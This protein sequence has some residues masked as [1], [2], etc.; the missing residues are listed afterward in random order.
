MDATYGTLESDTYIPINT[1]AENLNHKARTRLPQ[2]VETLLKVNQLAQGQL[3]IANSQK[4][5]FES[6]WSFKILSKK[7]DVIFD[8]VMLLASSGA[9]TSITG[10]G[11]GNGYAFGSGLALVGGAFLIGVSFHCCNKCAPC[12]Q[13]DER[14]KEIADQLVAAQNRQTMCIEISHLVNQLATL[15]AEMQAFN[16]SPKEVSIKGLFD[17]L[18]DLVSQVHKQIDHQVSLE[19]YNLLL[20]AEI[21]RAFKKADMS[22]QLTD[23]WES[24]INSYPLKELWTSNDKLPWSNLHL[25]KPTN[26]EYLKY[27][28]LYEKQHQLTAV[29]LI[30][31]HIDDFLNADLGVHL[32]V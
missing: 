19:V 26:N 1:F 29:K 17:D 15:Q 6:Q 30:Q 22:N 14:A 10:V 32:G 4:A 11:T 2:T 16:E 31:M 28:E 23:C 5:G 7:N 13:H 8:L 27:F 9:I 25:S 21:C 20:M 24:I 18:A 12:S 3:E